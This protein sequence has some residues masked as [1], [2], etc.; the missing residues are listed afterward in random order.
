LVS[1]HAPGWGAST[2]SQFSTGAAMFQSTPPG[3]GRDPTYTLDD[4]GGLFQSTP[5]G[6]GRAGNGAG[7]V[8]FTCFNP[9]PRVGGEWCLH[10]LPR[11][12]TVSI[13]APGWGA[14]G[15]WGGMDLGGGFNPR[16]RVGGE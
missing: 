3:G 5:P 4:V 10:E 1:I 8:T 16:P 11:T 7:K 2:T 14:R 15:A 13:H 9:R 6:G 12:L